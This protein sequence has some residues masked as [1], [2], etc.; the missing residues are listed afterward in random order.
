MFRVKS[1]P[2]ILG[3]KGMFFDYQYLKTDQ[4]IFLLSFN[5]KGKGMSIWFIDHVKYK[6]KKVKD[7]ESSWW[8][9]EEKNGAITLNTTLNKSDINI[10]IEKAGGSKT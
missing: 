10:E 5:G 2:E 8:Y 9:I 1:K 6:M 3:L 4:G 7:L